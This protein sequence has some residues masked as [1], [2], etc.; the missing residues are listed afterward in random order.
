MATDITSTTRFTPADLLRMPDG[1]RF[2]LVDGQL[3]ETDM[4]LRADLV[5]TRI[6]VLLQAHC[7]RNAIG[8]AVS[9]TS[10]QC[11]PD[12]PDRVRRPDVSVIRRERLTDSIMT[13]HVP[14]PPDLA[15][16][17]VSPND[18]FYDVERKVE[19]YLGAGVRLVWVV[20][21]DTQ[22][23]HVYR[24]N[25]TGMLIHSSDEVSGDD[26]IPGF[27]CKVEEFFKILP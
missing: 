26:V 12:D 2:E 21:P 14:I 8:S 9:E 27:K 24:A 19:E 4:S 18:I 7:E 16:E 23:V 25:R 3:V 17:V 13:G 5:K 11:F 6:L 15:V 1:D 20:N 22:A 10:Y